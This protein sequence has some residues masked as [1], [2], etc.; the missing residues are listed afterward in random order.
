MSSD[1]G[2]YPLLDGE[3]TSEPVFQF[4]ILLGQLEGLTG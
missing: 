1:L 3:V 2:D 4:E